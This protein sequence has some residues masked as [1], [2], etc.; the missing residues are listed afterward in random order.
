M[1]IWLVCLFIRLIQ[2]RIG[3]FNHLLDKESSHRPNWKL[4]LLDK[5]HWYILKVNAY[6]WYNEYSKFKCI[7]Y[8][9]SCGPEAFNNG[10]TKYVFRFIYSVSLAQHLT[11]CFEQAPFPGHNFHEIFAVW[12]QSCVSF[13]KH[14]FVCSVIETYRKCFGKSDACIHL[15]LFLNLCLS[16]SE[17]W[18]QS[19]STPYVLCSKS[20]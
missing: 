14:D 20:S 16:V 10:Y 3:Y 15:L 12:C 8:I 7:Q 11:I 9:C 18:I 4:N 6:S 19:M 2:T 13:R 5:T 1:D 17:R